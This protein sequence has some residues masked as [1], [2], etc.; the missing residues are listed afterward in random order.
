MCFALS[1]CGALPRSP[2]KCPIHLGFLRVYSTSFFFF[3]RSASLLAPHGLPDPPFYSTS[4]N[5]CYQTPADGYVVPTPARAGELIPQT[6]VYIDSPSHRS[7]GLKI[8]SKGQHSIGCHPAQLFSGTRRGV[9]LSHRCFSDFCRVD[10]PP[11]TTGPDFL[12]AFFAITVDT[13]S[14]T[15]TCTPSTS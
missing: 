8:C 1:C 6:P 13:S 11:T 5:G 12:Q 2:L 9:L 15:R 10:K 3:R 7:M 4:L 14:P